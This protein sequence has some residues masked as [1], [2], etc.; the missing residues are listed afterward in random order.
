MTD[1]GFPVMDEDILV[2]SAHSI[3]AFFGDL[4]CSDTQMIPSRQFQTDTLFFNTLAG[5]T[6]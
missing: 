1:R 3:D 5:R 4:Q 2:A 6:H